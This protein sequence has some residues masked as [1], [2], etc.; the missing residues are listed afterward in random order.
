M[1]ENEQEIEDKDAESSEGVEQ[2]SEESVQPENLG[3]SEPPA[4]P[5]EQEPEEC[6]PCVKVSRLDGDLCGHG[7]SADGLFRAYPFF[8]SCECS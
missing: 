5:E 6:E 3:P 4:E 7:H 8:C 2:A 1:S